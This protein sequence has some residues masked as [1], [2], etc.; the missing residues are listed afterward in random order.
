MKSKLIISKALNDKLVSLDFNQDIW[1]R[2]NIKSYAELVESILSLINGYNPK[3]NLKN[4]EAGETNKSSS[5]YGYFVNIETGKTISYFFSIPPQRSSRTAFLAQDVYPGL[6]SIIE[7][8]NSSICNDV[9]NCPVYIINLNEEDI[10]NS[11]EIN[12]RGALTIGLHYLDIFYRVKPTKYKS[13]K[14]LDTNLITVSN[15][16]QNNYFELNE[17][18]KEILFL[19]KTLKSNTNDRYFYASKSFP[20]AHLGSLEGYKLNT[21]ELVDTPNTN[22]NTINAFVKYAKKINL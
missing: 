19:N 8:C 6:T 2:I 5:N 14:E 13:I 18:D 1:T 22:N 17:Y 4:I 15:E 21:S 10:T 16:N 12:L 11:M 7:L 20:A 9:F 3:L